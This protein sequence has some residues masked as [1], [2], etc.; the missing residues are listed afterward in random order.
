MVSGIHTVTNILLFKRDNSL[1]ATINQQLFAAALTFLCLYVIKK[2]EQA[3]F[4][5][6][7]KATEVFR[8][9]LMLGLNEPYDNNNNAFIFRQH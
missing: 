2:K 1:G 5:E 8:T 6:R 7:L 4:P 9:F 3:L